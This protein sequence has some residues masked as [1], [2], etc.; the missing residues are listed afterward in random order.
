MAHSSLDF[1]IVFLVFISFVYSLIFIISFLLLTWGYVCSSFSSYWSIKWGAWDP[2]PFFLWVFTTINF[3]F[4]ATF[5]APLNFLYI[6]GFVCL[7]IFSNFLFFYFSI[8][9]WLLRN[10]QFSFYIF[11]NYSIFF[12]YWFLV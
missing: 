3:L 8:V 6:F 11:V 4:S 10:M 9:H 2:S 5:A 12:C 7:K 1:S